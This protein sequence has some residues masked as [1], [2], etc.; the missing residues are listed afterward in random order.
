M[1]YNYKNI[2]IMINDNKFKPTSKQF[3]PPKTETRIILNDWQQ[4]IKKSNLSAAA[5]KKIINRSGS[6]YLSESE[7]Y[8]PCSYSGCP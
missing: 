4:P 5:R 8:G 2:N 1:S 6:N 7:G 3:N